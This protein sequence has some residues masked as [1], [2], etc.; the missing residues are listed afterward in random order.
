MESVYFADP[1]TAADALRLIHG[2]QLKGRPVVVQF[3]RKPADRSEAEDGPD[4]NST[5]IKS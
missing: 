5:S 2:Y 3:G 4:S 1:E